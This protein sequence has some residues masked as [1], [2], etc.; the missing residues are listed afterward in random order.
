MADAVFATLEDISGPVQKKPRLSIDTLVKAEIHAANQ[1]LLTDQRLATVAQMHT[2]QLQAAEE[3][4]KKSLILVEAQKST[5][6]AARTAL[7][8]AQKADK[9]SNTPISAAKLKVATLFAQMHED[10]LQLAQNN[11]TLA[12]TEQQVNQAIDAVDL[13][14]AGADACTA[15][16]DSLMQQIGREQ[17]PCDAAQT[18]AKEIAARLEEAQMLLTS[19]EQRKEP[20]SVAE[21]QAECRFLQ[22]DL[23]AAEEQVAL[24]MAQL[25]T[26]KQLLQWYQSKKS[27]L[28]AT[29][30]TRALT[31]KDDQESVKTLTA[32]SKALQEQGQAR[33]GEHKHA[34]EQLHELEKKEA[35]DQARKL[36][37]ER[38]RREDQI[39]E[40]RNEVR[41]L[42]CQNAQVIIIYILFPKLLILSFL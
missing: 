22:A 3:K 25:D 9:A 27:T 18:K 16:I 12:T 33:A 39:A 32:K 17:I 30:E 24:L 38:V 20:K 37:Q 2:I 41:L 21:Q 14:N 35:E 31:I 28:T 34:E 23:Q 11:A 15:P 10:R 40:L 8:A 29:A 13:S 4:V 19:A 1:A 7:A 5:L 36:E 42:K 6:E 26:K